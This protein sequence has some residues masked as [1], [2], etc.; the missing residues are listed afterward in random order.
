MTL[1]S[2]SLREYLNFVQMVCGLVF[3]PADLSEMTI[4][5]FSG[6]KESVQCHSSALPTEL[7]P[8]LQKNQILTGF[9]FFRLAPIWH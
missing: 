5:Y 1:T 2:M 6:F 3:G 4:E 9:V 8:H 7:W